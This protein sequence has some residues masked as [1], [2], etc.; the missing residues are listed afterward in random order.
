M[1][2]SLP[3]LVMLQMLCL[4]TGYPTGAPTGACEDMMPRH[5][6]VLPQPSPAPY[7][8]LVN[9][10]TFQPGKAITVTISGPEYRGV[11]LEARTYGSTNAIGSWQLPPPDT[12]FLECTGNPQGAITHS[13]INLKADSTA[14]S[15]IPPNSTSPVYFMATVAQQRAVFW[16]NVRSAALTRGKPASLGLATGASAEMSKEKPVLLLGIC[17]LMIL[18]LA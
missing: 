5:T 3:G 7:T 15:W 12:K 14:Y 4:A 2:L 16:V 11:L 8:L 10:G 18:V 17:F 13:N 6:G 9:T 1:E